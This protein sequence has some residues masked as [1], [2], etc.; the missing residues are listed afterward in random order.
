M[1][2]KLL[3]FIDSAQSNTIATFKNYAEMGVI[4]SI[5]TIDEVFHETSSITNDFEKEILLPVFLSRCHSAYL[6]AVRLVTSGQVVE[7]YMLLRA[8]IENALYAHYIQTDPT[9]DNDLPERMT[10]WVKRGDD[11]KTL[12]AC[13]N[14]FTYGGTK[15]NLIEHN[16]ELGG[17]MSDLYE[18]T[19]DSGAHPNFFGHMTSSDVK[20]E[21]GSVD[22]LM[23]DTIVH[24]VGL[25]TTVK[26]GIVSLKI[27]ELIYGSRF[28]EQG[29][30][31]NLAS[32]DWAIEKT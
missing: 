5:F 27:F 21:G 30:T 4:T 11:K 23:P 18:R 14:M 8:C 20:K 16:K 17:K 24:K 10:T 13:R 7:T 3:G 9:L 22:V 32:L 6:A 12:K 19:L 31:E 29:I 2:N 15:R 26:I 28:S 25:Q 1:T